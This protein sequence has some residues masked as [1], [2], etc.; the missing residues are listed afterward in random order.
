MLQLA[1]CEE[2]APLHQHISH[3]LHI[4]EGQ[5]EVLVEAKVL[6]CCCPYFLPYPVHDVP[7][8]T[9]KHSI[10]DPVIIIIARVIVDDSSVIVYAITH[11]T[12]PI[13]GLSLI[14]WMWLQMGHW[15]WRL[16]S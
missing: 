13:I 9:K 5:A 8:S 10:I 14:S 16:A 1:L 11:F 15:I 6:P 2:Q 12:L 3:H 4:H 7:G